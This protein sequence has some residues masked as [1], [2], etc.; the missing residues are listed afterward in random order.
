MADKKPPVDWEKA[1][2]DYRAGLLTDREMGDKYGRSHGAIKQHMDKRGIERNLTARIRERTETKLSKAQLSKE[3]IQNGLKLTQDQ[4]I[5]FAAEVQTT[6]IIK[7]QG[8][9]GRHLALS[10]ALLAELESQTI[11]RELYER[12]GEMMDSPDKNGIDKLNELYRKVIT[13]SQRIDSHKKAVET[14]KNLI[15]MER[16]AYNMGDA[17][18]SVEPVMLVERVDEHLVALRIGF[19]KIL[20]H[21]DAAG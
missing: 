17:P 16:Q 2:I 13:T 8:R 3:T 21:A 6:I 7:Q 18:V 11:N 9:I 19:S 4:T 20:N 15:A 5:E 1:E 14:E 10:Q 12:L